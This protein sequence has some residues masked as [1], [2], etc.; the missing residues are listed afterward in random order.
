MSACSPTRE[1]L[2]RALAAGLEQYGFVLAAWLE[3]ADA[4]ERVDEYSDI[5][6]WLDVED[7]CEGDA[8][9]IVRE[10]LQRL[11]PLDFALE[12]E[13]PHPLIRQAFFRL[14]G[15]PEFQV[16]DTCVQ[17]HSRQFT[18]RRGMADERVSVLFDRA[19]AIQCQDLDENALRVELLER[20]GKL[21]RELVL[22]PTWV[23]K[24][25]ERGRFLEALGAYHKHVLGPLI[26]ALRL[27]H[28]PTK[29]EFHL[30][31]ATT[32]LPA[33]VVARLDGLYQVQDVREIGL[34]LPD[35]LELLHQALIEARAS[36]ESVAKSSD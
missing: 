3:G 36:L 22:Y 19:E 28:T 10:L 21:E 5:D 13:H 2:V 24:E 34:L 8:L 1:E 25:L 14:S 16:V 17:S 32:D 30:K 18:F 33:G 11:G 4:H 15:A 23:R 7:G 35:A 9:D 31:D 6:L 12:V 20:V 27:R 29:V 26:E